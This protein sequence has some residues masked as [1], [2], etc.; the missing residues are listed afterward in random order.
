MTASILGILKAST[1]GVQAASAGADYEYPQHLFN[2]MYY[3][4]AGNGSTD[5]TTA[6]QSAITACQT[7]GGGVVYFPPGTYLVTPTSNPALTVGAGGNVILAGAGRNTS[8]IKKSANGVALAMN[9]TNTAN[10][11]MY[12]GIRDLGFYGNNKTGAQLQMYY[13]SAIYLDHV[14]FTGNADVCVD[15]VEL[16]DS[17][18]YDCIWESNGPQTANTF[19]PNVYLR[20]S[21]A[22][23]GFGY[24]ADNVNQ[25]HFIGCRWESFSNG[26]LGISAGVNNT[27]SPNGIYVTNCKMESYSIMGGPFLDTG[28]GQCTNIH[29]IGLYAY[30]GGFIGG[31]S[32]PVNVINFVGNYMSLR[33]VFIGNSSNNTVR[34]GVDC[35]LSNSVLDNIVGNY[36]TAPNFGTHVYIE[37][38][39]TG[40][41]ATGIYSTLGTPLGGNG[42]AFSLP[43][44]GTTWTNNTG[45]T[46]T[47][48]CTAVG[49]VTAVSVNSI[50]V[51]TSLT[52]GNVFHIP[53]AGTFKATYSAA[54]T[55]VAVN[56]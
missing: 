2:V 26:A 22:A 23:S 42:T 33:N 5:D 38:G 40:L 13:A 29:V 52:K 19:S 48:Y 54:P 55:L 47:L 39:G 35:Y 27:N 41:I 1:A 15:A 8:I 14:Y 30:A 24:S 17:R 53:P 4:A 25:V 16:W 20:N 18:F 21:A 11:L 12:G 7:A 31:Y 46:V 6:I 37:A 44:S 50:S 36:T 56:G 9:G 32:T 45:Q 43:A 34:Q 3:G 51:G 49:T 10:H 28:A